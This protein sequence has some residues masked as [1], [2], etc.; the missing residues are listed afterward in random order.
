MREARNRWAHQKAFTTDD[1]CRALDRSGG[2]EL[3]T[4]AAAIPT[5]AATTPPKPPR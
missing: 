5:I 2:G 1:T 3:I 4:L